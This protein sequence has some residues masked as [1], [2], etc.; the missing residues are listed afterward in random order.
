MGRRMAL[1]SGPAARHARSA[2]TSTAGSS[3]FLFL[4]TAR[5]SS[6]AAGTEARVEQGRQEL[7]LLAEIGRSVWEAGRRFHVVPLAL[8]WR[9]GPRASAAS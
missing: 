9:K 4:R 3:V 6:T 7:D 8:F 2:G 5:L 1:A